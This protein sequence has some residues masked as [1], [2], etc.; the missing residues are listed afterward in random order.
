MSTLDASDLEAAFNKARPYLEKGA[1]ANGHGGIR[2][3]AAFYHDPS[4]HFGVSIG[5][6][7]KEGREFERLNKLKLSATLGHRCDT[8]DLPEAAADHLRG[9]GVHDGARYIEELGVGMSLT[10]FGP[11]GNVSWCSFIR[12]ELREIHTKKVDIAA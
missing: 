10:G 4:V 8:C 5:D 3:D 7:G 11:Y 2:F 1:A 12:D 6:P 9:A